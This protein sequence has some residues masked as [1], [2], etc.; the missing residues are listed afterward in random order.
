MHNIHNTHTLG[1][2]R[3][4]ICITYALS[5][6]IHTLHVL[7]KT[8]H[9]TYIA[10]HHIALHY[11]ALQCPALHDITLRCTT[12]HYKH[13]RIHTLHAFH[14]LHILG[15]LHTVHMLQTIPAIHSLHALHILHPLHTYMHTHTQTYMHYLCITLQ[16]FRVNNLTHHAHI[17]DIRYIAHVPYTA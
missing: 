2:A 13:A 15:T 1:L 10:M 16:Q 7:H 12:L 9:H 11:N 4:H 14:A 17:H 3:I 5:M 6:Y 8:H